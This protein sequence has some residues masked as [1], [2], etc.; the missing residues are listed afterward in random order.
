MAYARLSSA[1]DAEDVVQET[2]LKAFRAFD[3]FKEGTNSKAWLVRILVNTIRDHIRKDS[4]REH[5]VSLDEAVHT[6]ASSTPDPEEQFC[7]GELDPELQSALQSLPE[8][9]LTPFLLRELQELSYQEIANTLGIPIGTVMSRLSR[10]REM[11]R[12][13]LENSSDD[14]LTERRS[15]N[16]QKDQFFPKS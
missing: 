15:P 12:K 6:V 11:L 9:F 16:V 5:M 10:A 7:R 14:V 1:E 8:A 3:S 4:R 13:A 2:Y